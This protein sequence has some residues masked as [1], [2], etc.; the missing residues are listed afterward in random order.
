MDILDPVE[1]GADARVGDRFLGA[2]HPLFFMDPKFL[3]DI[4]V[5]NTPMVVHV[6]YIIYLR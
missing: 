3:F 2:E 5:N 1:S 6:H 4:L